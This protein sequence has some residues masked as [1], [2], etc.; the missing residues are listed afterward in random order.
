MKKYIIL[1]VTYAMLSP[2]VSGAYAIGVN[3]GV[4]TWYSQWKLTPANNFKSDPALMY[5]PVLGVDLSKGWSLTSVLLTGNFKIPVPD[6]NDSRNYRRYDSDTALNYSLFK[7]LKLFGG[8]KYMRYDGKMPDGNL[9]LPFEDGGFTHASIGPAL[10]VG[11][12]VP[13]AE[14]LFALVNF[15]GMYLRGK[16][17]QSGNPTEKFI[18]SGY[19]A[20]LSVAYYIASIST[21]LIAG[22]RYQYFTMDFNSSTIPESQNRFYGITASVVYNFNIGGDE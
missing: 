20:T 10:G 18:E 1:L 15:S 19:N 2:G 7:W 9:L 11:V 3:V 17:E 22:V 13:V 14:S 21:T 6:G 16:E 12:T 5:G 8:V 4:N